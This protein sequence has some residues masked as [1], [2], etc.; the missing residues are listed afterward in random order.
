[1]TAE[2]NFFRYCDVRQCLTMSLMVSN[3]LDGKQYSVVF[4]IIEKRLYKAEFD[5]MPF[6]NENVEHRLHCSKQRHVCN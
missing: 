1:M 6:M 5:N 3:V 4:C 2:H